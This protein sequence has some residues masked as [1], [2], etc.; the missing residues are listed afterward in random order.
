M[1]MKCLLSAV[2]SRDMASYYCNYWLFSMFNFTVTSE[3]FQYNDIVTECST[4][5]DNV[6]GN[7]NTKKV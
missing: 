3:E 5:Q 1:K 4:V 6:L 2:N 7:T